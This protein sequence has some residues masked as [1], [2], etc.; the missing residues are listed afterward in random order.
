MTRGAIHGK[1]VQVE[2]RRRCA[3]GLNA[4]PPLLDTNN[5]KINVYLLISTLVVNGCDF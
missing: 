4:N 2:R 1:R 5:K 3:V